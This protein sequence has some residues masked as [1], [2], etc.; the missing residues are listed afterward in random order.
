MTRNVSRRRFIKGIGGA[1]AAASFPEVLRVM[2]AGLTPQLLVR[3]KAIVFFD[4][5]FP[6]VDGCNVDQNLLQT[7]LGDFD[8]TYASEPELVAQLKVDRFN[9]LITPYGSAFPKRAWPTVFAYL[10]AGG[11]LLNLGGIPFSVPVE[12]AGS[13]WRIESRQTAYH[14]KLGITQ[15]FPVASGAIASYRSANHFRADKIN[16][17]LNLA[18]DFTP[19]KIY[20]LYVR[21]S[22]S[23]LIPDESGS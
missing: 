23:N 9:L 19:E 8:V 6:Q 3:P 15:S 22:S 5:E 18:N 10:R 13:Q 20:E 17:D 14:K 21:F 11:N 2:A 16:D 1:A 7:A 12:R 4:P